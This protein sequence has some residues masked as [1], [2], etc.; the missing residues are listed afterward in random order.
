MVDK[1]TFSANYVTM[2][3]NAA[4]TLNDRCRDLV[5]GHFHQELK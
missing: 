5:C 2:F 4:K 3:E 1:A